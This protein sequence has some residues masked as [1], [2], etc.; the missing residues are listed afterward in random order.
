MGRQ[1]HSKESII[2][3]LQ[4]CAKRLGK[5]TLTKQEVQTA[6][7]VSSVT[8]HFGSIGNALEAAGLQ[9]RSSTD[10]L[11]Q[12]RHVLTDDDLFRSMLE[13]E[14]SLGHPPGH[15]EY[16]GGGKYSTTPFTDRFGKWSEVLA[17]Y[18]K[19]EIR[20]RCCNFAYASRSQSRTASRRGVCGTRE[21]LDEH[22]GPTGWQHPSATLRGTN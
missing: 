1:R 21:A 14:Q 13:L 17:H 20:L 7:P 19:M 11:F 6:V 16:N 12:P 2:Q 18:R 15:N 5:D 8:F 9:R 22:E 3:V 4:N 10:H